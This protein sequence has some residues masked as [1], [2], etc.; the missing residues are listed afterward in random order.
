MAFVNCAIYAR[1]RVTN[2]ILAHIY[3]LIEEKAT[4]AIQLTLENIYKERQT[5]SWRPDM[6]T[7]RK[8]CH[9]GQAQDCHFA[10][11]EPPKQE[12]AAPPCTDLAEE[13]ERTKPYVGCRF[14]C[15]RTLQQQIVA[16]L[17]RTVAAEE[18][19]VAAGTQA[20]EARTAVAVAEELAG[21]VV[22]EEE[23]AR[24]VVGEELVDMT[25]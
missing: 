18:G 23:L 8:D 10:Q 6:R 24:T 21:T 13:E 1:K 19:A 2:T 20:E 15:A 12:V 22:A 25:V 11:E 14:G 4:V 3:W 7:A 16:A 5:L 17:A 9:S